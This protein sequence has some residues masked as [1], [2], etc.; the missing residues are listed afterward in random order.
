MI[1]RS[2]SRMALCVA[3]LIFNLVFIWGNSMLPASVSGALSRW[4]RDLLGIVSQGSE[5]AGEGLLRKL[6]HFG[7]FCLLGMC[8][9]WLLG[10]LMNKGFRIAAMAVAGGIFTACVDE[11][12]Q[13][14]SP[15]RN[16]SLVDVG[17]DT[18][19]AAVGMMLLFLGYN[20]FK[21]KNNIWR[22]IQ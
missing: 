6:A 5:D 19:G 8:L 13:S 4:L 3:L 1:R 11:A 22:K 9:S 18:A 14:L 17:I 12:I 7:E 16:P 10:M 2:K 21:N 15:G 20:F